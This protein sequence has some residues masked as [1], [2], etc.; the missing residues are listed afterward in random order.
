MSDEADE[1]KEAAERAKEVRELAPVSLT[2]AI[3]AVLVATVTL[4]GHRAHTEELLLQTKA[5]DQWSYYQAKNMRRNNLEALDE[6]LTAL[7]NTKAERAEE[8]H[9]H[10]REEIDKYRDQQKDIQGEAKELEAEVQKA[11]R[12]ADRFD[13]G[14]V[15]LEIALVVTS[16][17]LLTER[18]AYWYFGF[19][20]AAIGIVCAASGLLLR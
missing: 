5:T 2:M 14:E 12:R 7:E 11:S 19:V 4:L 13:L 1:L 18:R 8:I 9:K 15:F 6:V 20:L 17:T 3:L 16:I 10:F